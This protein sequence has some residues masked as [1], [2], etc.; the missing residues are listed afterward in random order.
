MILDGINAGI[1]AIMPWL[2]KREVQSIV[3]TGG[4]LIELP[5]DVYQ[6]EAVYSRSDN[7]WLE[8]LAIKPGSLG[9]PS[10]PKWYQ[11]PS[12]FITLTLDRADETMDVYY[13]TNWQS[14][15]TSGSPTENLETPQFV[16]VALIYYACSYCL[17]SGA[18]QSSQLRQFNT[19]IDSGNPE[20]NPLLQMSNVLMTR[21][22]NEVKMFPKIERSQR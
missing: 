15:T 20:D 12:G 5:S 14:I 17:A 3:V 2:P 19:R 1:N 16:D 11:Y 10:V 21:F 4:S 22:L 6:V 13:F 9:S 7:Y 18:M 8:E